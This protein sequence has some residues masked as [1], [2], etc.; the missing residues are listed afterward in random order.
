[1][2]SGINFLDILTGGQPV[3]VNAS[4]Q[5]DKSVTETILIAGVVIAILITLFF[6]LKK[7]V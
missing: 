6:V 1:M 4:V 3:D 5:A 7:F 2:N